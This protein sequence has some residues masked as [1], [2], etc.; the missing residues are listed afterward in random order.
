MHYLFS[1]TLGYF[2]WNRL[3]AAFGL[4][5]EVLLALCAPVSI[6]T[7]NPTAKLVTN[8]LSDHYYGWCCI[9]CLEISISLARLGTHL[10]QRLIRSLNMHSWRCAWLWNPEGVH[11]KSRFSELAWWEERVL[12]LDGCRCDSLLFITSAFHQLYD[13]HMSIE[14]EDFA[15]KR[16]S[17]KRAPLANQLIIIP[18][19]GCGACCSQPVWA[20]AELKIKT[21]KKED[22]SQ[23]R[24]IKEAFVCQQKRKDSD[25][26]SES[27]RKEVDLWNKMTNVFLLKGTGGERVKG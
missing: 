4:I 6:Q 14:C 21:A 1:P 22:C 9:I 2:G 5:W 18:Q 20:R 23:F 12:H 25:R 11:V 15:H 17:G 7:A 26:S 16:A 8:E 3:T 13:V 10:P 19:M 24:E 27:L